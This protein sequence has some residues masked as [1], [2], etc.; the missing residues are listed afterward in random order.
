VNGDGFSDLLVGA[1]EWDATEMDVG[2][3]ALYLGS[4]LGLNILPAWLATGDQFEDEWGSSVASA[5]DVN[6]DGYDDI[7]IGSHNY[8][9]PENEEGGAFLW[10]ST[11]GGGPNGTPQNAHWSAFGG[12]ANSSFGYS[13]AAA[14][15]V[16]GD[17]FGD[18]IVGAPDYTDGHNWEGGAFIY[19]GSETGPS[20]GPDWFHGADQVVAHYGVSVASAGDFDGDGYSDV[21][22]GADRYDHPTQNEGAAFVYLGSPDGP[23]TGAPEWFAQGDQSDCDFGADVGSA[24]DVNGDGLSDVIIGARRYNA[25]AGLEGM[26]F[27]WYGATTPPPTGNPTNADWSHFGADYGYYFGHDVSSAGDVNGDGYSDIVVSEQRAF[28]DSLKGV[29]HVWY[30]TTYG[31][32][33]GDPDWSQYGTQA[34]GW[35]GWDVGS[36]GDVNGDGFG[37]V[38]VGAMAQSYPQEDEGRTYLYYGNDSR[39]ISRIP[40]QM[41][42]DF[43]APIGLLCKSDASSAFGLRARGRTPMG[44]GDVRLEWEVKPFGTPFDGAGLGYG[45]WMETNAPSGALGS[46]VVLTEL[47]AGLAQDTEYHW[48]FR[49]ATNSPYFPHSP[50]LTLPYNCVTEMDLRT[51]ASASVAGSGAPASAAL[52]LSIHPNPVLARTTLAY[53]LPERTHV[54]LSIYDAEGRLIRKLVEGTQVAGEQRF[55]WDAR[56]EQGRRLAAGVYFVRLERGAATVSRKILLMP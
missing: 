36:A 22:V 39:G 23:T 51:E 14:G 52:Q 44:R 37:D 2:I 12:Q 45:T 32:V 26:A 56:D 54:R 8:T 40:Q 6:G 55:V 24:G 41:R 27:V 46:Y 10:M 28:G 7:L 9:D 49:M 19:F 17:G 11:P 31:L 35:F 33:E 1:P 42:S 29:V 3:V 18:I 34:Y 20:T 48:R 16:N 13:V 15:D 43:S 47:V 21:I 38:I 30:G 4:H 53:M 50:W 5:G 25:Y